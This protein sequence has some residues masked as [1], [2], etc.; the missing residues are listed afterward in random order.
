M[1]LPDNGTAWPPRELDDITPFFD[2]WDAWYAGD[3]DRLEAVY[4]G[5]QAKAP[6]P[7]QLAGGIV[8]AVSRFFWGRPSSNP[9]ES[10]RKLHVPIAADLC[11]AAADLVWSEAP[12]VKVEHEA[13]QERL[14]T[15]I[16]DGALSTLAAGAEVG[17][18]LGGHYV[19]VTWDVTVRPDAPFLTTVDADGALPTFRWGHLVAV[20]FWRVVR[21]DGQQVWRHVEVHETERQGTDDIGVIRHGLYLGTKESLGRVVPLADHASTAG[22]IVGADS[23]VTTASRGLAVV[24]IPHIRPQRLWRRNPVGAGLGRSCF[25]GVEGLMDSLDETYT[26]WMRDIRLGKARLLVDNMAL[27][28][29]GPG[30]G[31]AFDMDREIFTELNAPPGS[32]T[33]SK[34]IAQAEQFAIRHE[35]HKATARELMERIIHDAGFSLATFGLDNGAAGAR[36]ATEI[37]ATQQRS[38]MTRDRMLRIIRPALGDVFEKLLAVDEAMFSTG[39]E[40]SRPEIE[41]PDGIQESM[42]TLAQTAMA[43]KA[44]EAAST[45]TLVEMI[46]PEW[47]EDQIKEEVARIL[48]ETAPEPVPDPTSPDA[49]PGTDPT[50]LAD[51]SVSG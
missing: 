18:A 39:V 13:T 21:A 7:S 35:E 43:L 19:R 17:A 29:M 46:H 47:D 2:Q 1:P 10:R 45:Q 48:E 38:F 6:R 34:M 12:S 3:Q 14:D 37:V 4:Q 24:Y 40:V 22:I 15:L 27:S 25:D 50:E 49:V 36:T 42:L 44:A 8:G 41:F 11:T 16:S 28:D 32:L 33:N 9:G 26:S 20:T 51:A 31:A 30:K 5:Q 23:T